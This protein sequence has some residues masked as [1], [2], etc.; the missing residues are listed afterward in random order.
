[1]VYQKLSLRTRWLKPIKL[2]KSPQNHSYRPN[3]LSTRLKIWK[4]FRRVKDDKPNKELSRLR[5][6]IQN[7]KESILN[8][9]SPLTTV[10]L[11]LV[12]QSRHW[13][14]RPALLQLLK[15]TKRKL[16]LRRKTKKVSCKAIN[17]EA[18]SRTVCRK[19]NFQN[20]CIAHLKCRYHCRL[21]KQ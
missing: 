20:K 11:F 4:Y 6:W 15:S 19:A 17:W 18:I 16:A 9:P 10:S 3:L 8:T 21:I 12:C 13:E 14:Y 7:L 1:M 5:N 2:T